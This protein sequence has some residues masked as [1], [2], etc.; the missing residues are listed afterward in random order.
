MQETLRDVGSIPG[1]WRSP[2]GEHSN[3]LQYSCPGNPTDRGAWQATVH[4]V[5]KSQ[6]GLKWLSIFKV[7]IEFVT[8]LFLFY[9]LVFWL[10]A[11][12]NLSSLTRNWTAPPALEGEILTTGPPIS[13]NLPHQ[14]IDISPLTTQ[15]HCSCSAK[16]SIIC[17]FNSSPVNGS[18]QPRNHPVYSPL[19][20]F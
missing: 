20:E 1:S 4:G 5:T 14:F 7:C 15:S 19:D 18:L 10:Q 3:P 9:I 2:G 8:I 12:W 16:L 11:M 17:S 6:T 13:P